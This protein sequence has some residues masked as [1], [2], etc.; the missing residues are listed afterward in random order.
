MHLRSFNRENFGWESEHPSA[1]IGTT[2]SILLYAYIACRI[3]WNPSIPYTLGTASSVL[4]KKKEVSL[5]QGLLYT[6]FYVTAW[7]HAWCPY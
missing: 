1:K 4:I 7:D 5:F 2:R 3:Q 6:L